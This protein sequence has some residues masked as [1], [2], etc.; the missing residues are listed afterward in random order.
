MNRNDIRVVDKV[1]SKIVLGFSHPAMVGHELFPRVFVPQKAGKIIQ[2]GKEGFRLMNT[3][4]APGTNT[5]RITV[6]YEA[7]NYSTTNNALDAVIPFE[8]LHDAAMLPNVN[9]KI[10][11]T[12][13]VMHIEGNNLEN[14]QAQLA[15]DASK[16]SASNKVTLSGTDQWSDYANSD[17]IGD[18]KA[19]RAAIRAKTGQYP[20]KM[21]IPVQVHEILCEHPK[22]LAKLSNNERKILAV[23]DYQ[24]IFQV[25]KV[26]IAGSIV[27]DAD[28]E[29]VDLWGR[30]V[31][32]AVVPEAVTTHHQPSFGYTYTLEGHPNVEQFWV[33]R[34]IKSWVGG[35]DY[36]RAPLLTG[37]ESGFLIQNAVAAA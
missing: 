36:E 12:N 28:E 21:V 32:L 34:A 10:Q 19:A 23:A 8:W 6:G 33:D 37:I 14:E 26:V 17:P 2:F 24:E 29:F 15:R 9:L 1:L 16:Y 30:D 7:G 22:M 18:V 11:A 31:I 13:T 27:T 5:K 4:R 25:K 3:R 20:N 35:V